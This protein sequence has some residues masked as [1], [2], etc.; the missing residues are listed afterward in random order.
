MT[1]RKNWDRRHAEAARKADDIRRLR[2]A[3]RDGLVDFSLLEMSD[4]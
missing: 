1:A 3:A 2:E 4:R